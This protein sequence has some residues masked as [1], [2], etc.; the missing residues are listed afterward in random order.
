MAINRWFSKFAPVTIITTAA[1][2]AVALAVLATMVALNGPWLG[3]EFDRTYDGVGVRIERVSDGSP[4]AG[5]LKAGDIIKAFVSPAH[6]KVSVYSTDTLEDPD[7]LASY[8]EYN[9]FFAHQQLLWDS[10]SSPSLTVILRNGRRVDLEPGQYPSLSVLPVEYWWLLFF[11]GA[12][13]LLGVSSWSMRRIEPVTRV[14]AVSGVG[15]M[16]GAYSCAIYVSRELALPAKLFFGLAATNHLGIMTFAYASILFFW[17]YPRR[18]GNAPAVGIYAIGVGALWLNET[19]QWLSWPFHAFYAHFVVAYCLLVLLAILQWRKSRNAPLD[20]A[21]LKWLLATMLLSLGFTVLL[22]YS[23]IILIGES[24]ASNV[25]TFCAVFVFYLGLVVGNI[26]YRQFDMDHWWLRAGQ[27]LVFIFIALIADALFVY[28]LHIT[29]T[30][31]LGL[32]IGVGFIYLLI[33]HWLWGRFSGNSGRALDRAL[34]YLADMFNLQQTNSTPEKQW[35]QLIARVFNPLTVKTGAGKCDSVTIIQ[36]GMTLQLPSLDGVGTIE[37]F[38]CDQGKRL[39]NVSD[40][41]LTNR[42]LEL[43]RRSKENITAREQGAMEERQR[44][45]RDLHD[46]VAARLLS[47]LHQTREPSISKVAQN[48]LQGLRDVVHLLGAE[49]AFLEDIITDIEASTRE[50]LKGLGV[51]LEW[52]SP[53]KFPAVMLSSQQHINLRRIARETIANA[54]KHAHPDNIH[55]KVDLDH[56]ELCMCIGNDGAITDPSGWIPNRGLNNIK[57]R[58]DEMGGSHKWGI[59]QMGTNTRY[60]QLTVRMPLTISE[61]TQRHTSD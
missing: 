1:I 21:M 7:H 43:M 54:L 2:L 19:V 38:C 36:T 50:Q 39:F 51:R 12:S 9:A 34:P 52:Q 58:V 41:N 13:F 46:D 11:G 44:I 31:S 32:A 24:I 29:N 60:C 14:L 20:R 59:E 27:W 42:L 4:A 16:L 23:P 40:V 45:Q 47:L 18:L 3:I 22:F 6:G 33:R 49:D 26:R 61:E 5:K 37:A 35:Q 28:F 53:D 57:S 17:Y 30:A 48:A 15:Y 25:M 56:K 8:A 10:L 55:L